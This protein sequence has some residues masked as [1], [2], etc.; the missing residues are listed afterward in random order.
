MLTSPEA[1]GPCAAPAMQGAS[2]MPLDP[3]NVPFSRGTPSMAELILPGG[4]AAAGDLQLHPEPLLLEE[5]THASV[6]AYQANGDRTNLL[7][8]YLLLAGII[9]TAAGLS[10]AA[11]VSAKTH[12]PPLAPRVGL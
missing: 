12:G 10:P 4:A 3:A 9:A 1:L 8:L 6:V 5:V 7:N 11:G 2:A